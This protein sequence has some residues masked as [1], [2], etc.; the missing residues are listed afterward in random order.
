MLEDFKTVDFDERL[1]KIFID[2]GSCGETSCRVK[3]RNRG[4]LKADGWSRVAV[5]VGYLT[6]AYSKRSQYFETC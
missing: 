6:R 1:A 3:I 4:T 5:R 2:L